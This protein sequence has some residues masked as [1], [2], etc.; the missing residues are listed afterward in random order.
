MNKLEN[1]LHKIGL[2]EHESA[3]YLAA[4][5]LGPSP[6][7]AIARR[8]GIKRTTT[9]SV[10]DALI[11]RGL[12]RSEL[13]GLKTV[14]V[15]E[16]PQNLVRVMESRKVELDRVLP[17]L[18]LLH[19]QQGKTDNI[20]RYVGAEGLKSVYERIYT[21]FRRGDPYYV[22]GG[23][24]GWVDIDRDY[25]DRMLSRKSRS[26]VETKLLIQSSERARMHRQRARQLNQEVR[27]L[28]QDLGL[29]S[30]ILITKERVAIMHLTHP[31]FGIVIENPDV[32]QT[33]HALFKYLWAVTPE[34]Q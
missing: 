24:H 19:Q 22:I 15:A 7:L 30:D 33:Y 5:S 23:G 13:K 14:F 2:T 9:Y 3:V 20:K 34:E 26:G 16:D 10:I 8:A 17:D 4:L 31:Y 25:Q 29:S 21:S 32:V 28:P 11:A 27:V 1:S 12:M 6:V 18:A